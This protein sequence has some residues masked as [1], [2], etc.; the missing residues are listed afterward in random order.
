MTISLT[1]GLH[2]SLRQTSRSVATVSGERRQDFGTFGE[3]VA[4]LA[5]ALRHAG[6][7]PNDRVGMLALNS[8]RY[9]EYYLATM[10]SGGVV[11]PCNIRWSPVEIAHSLDD[12][13][14]RILVVDDNFTPMLP[15]LRRRSR[16]LTTIIHAGDGT[17]P[18]GTVSYEALLAAADPIEDAN[19]QG[20]DM[21][22][23]F[24][25]GGTI[26]TPKGVVLSHGNIFA[27]SLAL[28]TAVG[29]TVS[30]VYLHGAPMFHMADT[31]AG[32]SQVICGGSHVM[33]P[34]FTPDAALRAF[35]DEGVTLTLLVPLMIQMLVD[36]P[37][38][39]DIDCSSLGT[40][41][42]G[43]SPMSETVLRRPWRPCRRPRSSTS[44]A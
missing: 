42:Y 15:E 40:M 26:G 11:N 20:D 5:G 19:R 2:R 44:T 12:C 1:Q 34:R 17:P 38:Q 39:R 36:Y 41:L 16:C 29:T 6:M 18:D 25:T 28:A 33:I 4:R 21:A 24:Y 7:G 23:I 8:D 32:M 13:E 31:A 30:T 35:Q 27:S 22:G 3:R 37:G 9:L 43:A 10:W 14:T